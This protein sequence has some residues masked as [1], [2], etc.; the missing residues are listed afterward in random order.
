MIKDPNL[1][2]CQAVNEQ[3]NTKVQ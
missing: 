3:W 1:L 2:N